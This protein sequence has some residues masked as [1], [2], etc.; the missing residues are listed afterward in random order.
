MRSLLREPLVHFLLIGAALF[1]L[2]WWVGGTAPNPSHRIVITPAQVRQLAADWSRQQMRPPTSQ[3]L[4]ALIEAAVKEEIY[5]REA[6]ALGLDRE[7]TVIR[8]RLQQKMELVAEDMAA[9][10]DP[11][12]AQLQ[13]YLDRHPDTFRPERRLSLRQVFF[14]REKRG[15]AARRDAEAAAVRLERD[16][17]AADGGHLG[18][19]LPVPE[20]A[21][22]QPVSQVAQ[23][24]GDVF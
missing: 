18:D 6:V 13:T 23:L 16:P 15:D 10:L 14:S 20:S 4:T 1:A 5:A 7:D 22:P 19:P 3:E 2:S 21:E 9:A 12:D 8:R 24:F 17:G 11:T